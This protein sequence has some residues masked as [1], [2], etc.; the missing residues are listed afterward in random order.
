[1]IL[2]SLLLWIFPTILLANPGYTSLG[3][4]EEKPAT[5][6]MPDLVE[7]GVEDGDIVCSDGNWID[8]ACN[9]TCDG[10][11]Y[12][13]PNANSTVVCQSSGNWTQPLPAKCLETLLSKLKCFG[14]GLGIPIVFIFCLAM[15]GVCIFGQQDLRSQQKETEGFKKGRPE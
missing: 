15:L 3:V 4:N 2:R 14:Y 5:K 6:C 9:I 8:S 13:E 7:A 10:G 11:H 1:M 12:L